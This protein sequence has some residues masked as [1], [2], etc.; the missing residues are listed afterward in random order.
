MLFFHRF[1]LRS[2][3]LLRLPFHITLLSRCICCQ[4]TDLGLR[5]QNSA[6]LSQPVAPFRPPFIQ[7]HPPIPSNIRSSQNALLGIIRRT[8]TI[9]M[10]V[11]IKPCTGGPMSLTNWAPTMPI[12]VR[13]Y[14][15]DSWPAGH[16]PPPPPRKR[17]T[18]TQIQTLKKNQT[19]TRHF[20]VGPCT[21]KQIP[22][23]LS[24][25]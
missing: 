19:A 20:G 2:S 4:R 16:N 24:Y 18:Y 14:Q 7:S 23:L 5:L 12:V 3:H 1:L 13:G 21:L 8:T 22:V 17:T 15:P 10:S 25:K 11:T 9:I 6:A